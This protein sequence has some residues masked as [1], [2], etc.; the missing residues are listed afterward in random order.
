MIVS[1]L[2]NTLFAGQPES[3]DRLLFLIMRAKHYETG[4]K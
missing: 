1:D 4:S 2:N 3:V